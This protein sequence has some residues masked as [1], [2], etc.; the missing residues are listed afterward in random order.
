MGVLQ[1]KYASLPNYE[2]REEEFLA[3]SVLLRRRFT[4]DGIVHAHLLFIF[5]TIK[6]YDCTLDLA[7]KSRPWC[8]NFS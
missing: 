8:F 3:E 1:V 4:E 6:P 7:L 2:D 5:T